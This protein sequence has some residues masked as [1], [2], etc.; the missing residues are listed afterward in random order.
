MQH[1]STALKCYL[2]RDYLKDNSMEKQRRGGERRR[3]RVTTLC[4]HIFLLLSVIFNFHSDSFFFFRR[5][6]CSIINLQLLDL[7]VLCLPL[8]RNLIV[9]ALVLWFVLGTGLL[10][11]CFMS[12]AFPDLGLCLSLQSCCGLCLAQSIYVK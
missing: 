4:R 1:S 3:E 10:K 7:T 9:L 5:E 11:L 12:R 2:S 8:P 6:G